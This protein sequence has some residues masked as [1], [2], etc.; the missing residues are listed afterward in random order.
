[1]LWDRR[2]IMASKELDTLL[3]VLDQAFDK[4]SWHGANLRGSLR[5]VT[6][7]E[8]SWRPAPEGHN[9][10]ELTLHAAYWKYVV[11]RRFTGEP[12]GSFPHPGSNWFRRP[13]GQSAD[14]WNLDIQLLIAT[15]RSMRAAITQLKA[16]DLHVTPIGSTVSNFAII[17]GV[18]AHDLYHA[19]Q[20]QL[21]KRLGA[22][23]H[24]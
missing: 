15:H 23:Q 7:S 18:V 5:G 24:K 14:D 9:I 10:W 20:I 2:E 1:M 19:G 12:R 13:Q 22:K 16:S 4:K 21:L 6:D 17:S 8:A 3:A 11:R